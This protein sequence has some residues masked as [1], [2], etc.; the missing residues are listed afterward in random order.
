MPKQPLSGPHMMN[1][2]GAEC[3]LQ[4][5]AVITALRK[6]EPWSR[7]SSTGVQRA[8]PSPATRS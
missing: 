4:A 8:K 2:S 3:A 7:P 1:R 6:L 5:R